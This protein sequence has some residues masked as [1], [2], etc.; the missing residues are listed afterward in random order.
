MRDIAAILRRVLWKRHITQRTGNLASSMVWGQGSYKFTDFV[1]IG[2]AL[3]TL[4]ALI[5][6]LLTPMIYR[7]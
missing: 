1:K 5:T 4:E 6:I 3:A 2:A 7:F